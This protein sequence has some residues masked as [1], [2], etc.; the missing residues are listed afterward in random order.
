MRELNKLNTFVRVAEH[1]S[2]TK[3]AR[4]LRMTPS[5]VSKHV[6]ELETKLGFALLNR[7]THGVVLT[8][9][10][11]SF[12]RRCANILGNLDSAVIDARNLQK[13]P[14]GTLRIHAAP[15]YAHWVLAPLLPTFLR[16][17]PDLRVEVG[18]D[19]PAAGYVEAGFDIAV[20]AKPIADPG[21]V[22][23]DIGAIPYVVCASPDYFR[24]H[25]TPKHPR[26]LQ[27]HN[28]LVGTYFAPKEWPFKASSRTMV[29]RVK[30]SFCSD[31][32]AVLTE[33]ALAGVGIVRLPRYTVTEQLARGRLQAIF[34]GQTVSRQTMHLYHSAAKHLPA[35]TTLFVD[36]LRSAMADAR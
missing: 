31:N 8:E 19:T 6:H 13:T 22:R 27:R 14:H 18:T 21:L 24:A 26:D 7:S 34:E 29:V 12:A 33:V 17:Y 30:G 36:F 15:G 20:S 10:G 9:V 23:R 16:R 4:D 32:S 28:C 35:K 1:L 11:E 5:A 2:F 25:G 3:A